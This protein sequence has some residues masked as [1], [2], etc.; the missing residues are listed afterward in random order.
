MMLK[1]KLLSIII[2]TVQPSEPGETGE[3]SSEQKNKE[4]QINVPPGENMSDLDV[5]EKSLENWDCSN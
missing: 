1:Q 3:K 2:H 5:K 4:D